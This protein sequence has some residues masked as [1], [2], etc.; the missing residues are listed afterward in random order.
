[1]HSNSE[2]AQIPSDLLRVTEDMRVSN[3]E[4]STPE[5]ADTLHARF[6]AQVGRTPN[7]IAVTDGDVHIT[8]R[9]L[10]RR[11]NLI[12]VRLRAAGA[13]PQEPVGVCL[14]RSIDLIAVL[15]G[16]LKVGAFYVPLDPANPDSRLDFI[17]QD[18]GLKLVV[19]DKTLM[20]RAPGGCSAVVVDLDLLAADEVCAP[21]I[22]A[23]DLAYVIYTSGSTG[24]PKGVCIE[25][26]SVVRLFDQTAHWFRF[27]ASDVWTLFHSFA[28]DFSV[29]EIW[30][31]LLYGGR[32]VIVPEGVARQPD[33]Y[34]RLLSDEGITVLN[35]TPSAFAQLDRVDRAEPRLR[36]LALRLVIFGGEALDPRRLQ[37]WFNR[38]GTK[39]TLVNMYGIT[40][41][42]V[43]V[44]YKV[45]SPEIAAMPDPGLPIGRPIPDLSIFLFDED[46]SEV[47]VGTVGEIYVSGPG[48]ARGYLARPELT[49][50]RFVWHP[51]RP[52][53][54]LYRTGDLGSVCSNGEFEYHGRADSQVK[55][56]GFRIELGEIEAALRAIP[57]IREAAVAVQQWGADKNDQLVAYIVAENP[58][59][60]FDVRSALGRN[61]P[62]HMLPHAVMPIESLPLTIN[63]K[64]DRARLP[65][66]P[67]TSQVA[68]VEVKTPG[69]SV[70]DLLA[71]AWALTLGLDNVGLDTNPFD[72]G[73]T[74][75]HLVAVHVALRQEGIDVP[76]VALFEHPRIRDLAAFLAGTK[77]NAVAAA[78][79]SAL[80]QRSALSA[81][82][83]RQ[84]RR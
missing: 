3:A 46:G 67:Q 27:C 42:T 64:L 14:T 81:L 5:G 54:R 9:E 23:T 11:S 43:H 44:T 26:K 77:L 59:S 56:R 65:A 50:Q 29:W 69:T 71:R 15:L 41:T 47:S 83:V 63:G 16:V 57:G 10:D 79:A 6:S 66:R 31:A 82:K 13:Q 61:L 49:N 68:S 36:P 32:L 17:A 78:Q 35:Q 28:F 40:E 62:E 33:A 51:Q 72:L 53:L 22:D 74:S 24:V 30:G 1:M 52:S 84:G 75:Y 18:A 34:L 7:A 60:L 38:R 12:L 70:E 45:I 55:V 20:N 8:Y 73:A 39:A 21:A 58:L 37:S 4:I 19:T 80:R 48:L 25:H 76:I 2:H